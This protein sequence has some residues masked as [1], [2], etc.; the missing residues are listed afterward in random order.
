MTTVAYTLLPTPCGMAS[1]ADLTFYISQ[2]L[3]CFISTDKTIRELD[4]R[5]SFKRMYVSVEA[6]DDAFRNHEN[7]IRS[8]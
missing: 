2:T 4:N 8:L 6:T 7:L 5:T 3:L 1:S